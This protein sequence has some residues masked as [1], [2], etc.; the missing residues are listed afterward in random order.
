MQL[1]VYG[2]RPLHRPQ[3]KGVVLELYTV[4]SIPESASDKCFISQ[5]KTQ[6][7]RKLSLRKL[8]AEP[9]LRQKGT[10]LEKKSPSFWDY[11]DLLII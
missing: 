9:R 6:N 10:D 3:G 5:E 2:I 7:P 1:N 8:V 11:K 4:L